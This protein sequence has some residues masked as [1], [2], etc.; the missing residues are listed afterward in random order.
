MKK[1][2][3]TALL[4]SLIPA[5][6]QA[7]PPVMTKAQYADYSVQYRCIQQNYHDDLDKKEAELIKLEEQFG[8]NDDNFDAFDELVTEY[9]RDA[10][11][12][13]SIT[14]R[15]REACPTA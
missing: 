7:A 8:L 9:E 11:M 2:G 15:A 6:A 3:M 13:D 1:L 14:E 10:A 5:M 4:T 12:L